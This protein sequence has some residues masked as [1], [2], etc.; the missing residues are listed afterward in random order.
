MATTS[1]IMSL[2]EQGARARDREKWERGDSVGYSGL[3][4]KPK[5][6]FGNSLEHGWVVVRGGCNVLP[7][8][9]WGRS[10]D[11]ALM[12]ANV[13]LAVEGLPNEADRFWNLLRAFQYHA[14]KK[15]TV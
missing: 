7:G 3:T 2:E 5:R 11:E 13:F 8:A 12:L 14:K 4:I 15:G 10:M 6:D 1:N 9:T